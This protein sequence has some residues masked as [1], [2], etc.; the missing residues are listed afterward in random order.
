MMSLWEDLHFGLRMLAKNATFTLIATLTLALGT[1]AASVI[2]S[3]VD[4]VLLNP[5]PYRNADRLATPSISLPN[6]DSITRFPVS[7]FLDFKE[8]NRTFEDMIALAY[9]DVRW[10]SA[11]GPTQQFLG[12]WVTPNT[13]EFLGIPPLLGRQV[14]QEDGKLGSRPVVAMSYTLWTKLFNRDPKVLG[15]TLNLNGSPRTLIAIMPPRFRF[16]NCEVWMPLELSRSTFITGFGVQPNE[17][18]TV[19]RLKPGV[20]LQTASQTLELLRSAPKKRIPHGFAPIT[21]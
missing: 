4:S 18:W 1:G 19:G 11:K 9:R 20:S 5:L 13:F 6:P 10:K 3:V 21:G 14:T 15:A 17:L 8:Q 2:C 12:A 7:V 16:G